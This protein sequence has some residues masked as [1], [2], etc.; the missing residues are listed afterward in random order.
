MYIY[1]KSMMRS[2]YQK[3]HI[4]SIPMNI[5]VCFDACVCY[6]TIKKG[7]RI[8]S[9]MKGG[10]QK[11]ALGCIHLLSVLEPLSFSIIK[12]FKLSFFHIFIR[13]NICFSFDSY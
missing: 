5:H 7:I 11:N 12:Y 9:Q 6:F 2:V 13:N 3:I 4:Y 1:K 10:I 8:N